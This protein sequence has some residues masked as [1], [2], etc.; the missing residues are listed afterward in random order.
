MHTRATLK[1]PNKNCYKLNRPLN[2]FSLALLLMLIKFQPVHAFS[3]QLEEGDPLDLFGIGIHQEKRVDI[4]VGALFAP[5]QVN[6][7]HQL[8]DLDLNKRMTL[9]FVS[10]YSNRKMARFWKQRIAMNNSRDSWRPFTKEIITFANIF[11]SPIQPG[12][13]INIDY[14]ANKGTLIYLNGT[15]FLTVEKKEFF[16]LL[17]N[18]W[19][20]TIPPTEAFKKGITGQNSETDNTNLISQYEGIQPIIGRFDGDKVSPADST[21]QVAL[22]S[23]KPKTNIKKEIVVEQKPASKQPANKEQNKANVDSSAKE[24]R[25][26]VD[27][28]KVDLPVTRTQIDKPVLDRPAKAQNPQSESVVAN[29]QVQSN[30]LELDTQTPSPNKNP[31]DNLVQKTEAKT[32]TTPSEKVA[33]LDLPEEKLFDAD[34]LLGSYTLELINYIRKRQSYPKKALREGIEGSL[35][36]QIKIDSAGQIIESNYLQRSGKRTLDRAVMKTIRKAQPFPTI[37]EELDLQE[38]EFEVPMNF[39]I[40]D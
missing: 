10:K 35:T 19:I 4:Y 25:K 22:T 12:D 15:H 24:T 37:P 13:E 1:M 18:I 6:E 5:T 2:F 27:S 40:K 26:L 7:P 36:V 11:K 3:V 17:L 34:L 16:E 29:D 28:L 31:Q 8:V 30:R 14:I 38:F 39:S 20:G 21:T 23:S 32:E 33:K 9:R